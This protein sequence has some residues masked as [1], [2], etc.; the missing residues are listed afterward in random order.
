ML[1]LHCN[2]PPTFT[3]YFRTGADHRG[4][5]I[6]TNLYHDCK[7]LPIYKIPSSIHSRVSF[8]STGSTSGS[9][10]T[11]CQPESIA[12][13]PT[14][15]TRVLKGKKCKSM[16]RFL[17]TAFPVEEASPSLDPAWDWSVEETQ[18]FN[19]AG[20]PVEL[21][22]QVIEHCMHQPRD[23]T[24]FRAT[25]ARRRSRSSCSTE[26]SRWETGTPFFACP[27]RCVQL[28]CV[29]VSEVAAVWPLPTASASMLSRIT[30]FMNVWSD[31]EVITRWWRTGASQLTGRR[32]L[33]RDNTRFSRESIPVY[34][35]T[36]QCVTEFRKSA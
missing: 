30:A 34:L 9:I 32:W 26:L 3:I 29:S 17:S 31:L 22:E 8:R 19:W 6:T 35:D 16:S 11:T 21:K 2:N 15:A 18:L 23:R 12:G 10:T 4:L 13:S 36:L 5:T 14:G 25:L 27:G 20:L 7:S 33:W 1:H 24:T 28:L